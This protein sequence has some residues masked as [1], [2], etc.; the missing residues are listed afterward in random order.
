MAFYQFYT[1][2]TNGDHVGKEG[3]R[4][5]NAHAAN[6][7]AA[8]EIPAVLDTFTNQSG[9]R[10]PATDTTNLAQF[11]GTVNAIRF[12]I[13]EDN[14]NL[15]IG[16]V[17][18]AK[19]DYARVAL[20]FYRLRESQ[21]GANGQ[22]PSQRYPFSQFCISGGTNATIGNFDTA[23]NANLYG[24]MYFYGWSGS[25]FVRSWNNGVN[26]NGTTCFF[27]KQVVDNVTPTWNAVANASDIVNGGVYSLDA[28]GSTQYI[29]HKTGDYFFLQ[30]AS[31]G[32][33]LV[34]AADGTQARGEFP[35]A[36]EGSKVD[37]A[38]YGTRFIWKY[39]TSGVLTAYTYAQNEGEQQASTSYN[40]T[41]YKQTYHVHSGT[42]QDT[43]EPTCTQ[44][45]YDIYRCSE[46]GEPYYDNYVDATGHTFGSWT[47]ISDTQHQRVCT[48][49]NGAEEGGIEVA[50]HGITYTHNDTTHTAT[51]SV[52]GWTKTEAHSDSEI[53]SR[54][55]PQCGN[56]GAYTYACGYVKVIPGDGS[57]TPDG[58]IAVTKPT[59]TTAGSLTYMCNNCGETVETREIPAT[60]H[61]YNAD[62]KCAI[63]GEMKKVTDPETG[64]LVNYKPDGDYIYQY[65][66]VPEEGHEYVIANTN[67]QGNAYVAA[68]MEGNLGTAY[69]NVENQWLYSVPASVA[70]TG[71]NALISN[72]GESTRW[73]YDGNTFKNVATGEY[74]WGYH[75][76]AGNDIY[77]GTALDDEEWI[78]K[79]IGSSASIGTY[80]TFANIK[81]AIGTSGDI[82]TNKGVGTQVTTQDGYYLGFKDI[83]STKGFT[84]PG[85]GVLWLRN[86]DDDEA[87]SGSYMPFAGYTTDDGTK[88]FANGDNNFNAIEE[89]LSGNCTI[90]FDYMFTGNKSVLMVAR[91]GP[92]RGVQVTSVRLYLMGDCIF[93]V[94]PVYSDGNWSQVSYGHAKIPGFTLNEW[95]HFRLVST[96]TATGESNVGDGNSAIVYIDGEEVLKAENWS[97]YQPHESPYRAADNY[98]TLKMFYFQGWAYFNNG[99]LGT[100]VT[101]A[102]LTD[103]FGFTCTPN[104]HGPDH[105]SDGMTYV[106]NVYATSPASSIV[107]YDT[108]D[109][110]YDADN[111][112]KNNGNLFYNEQTAKVINLDGATEVNVNADIAENV[113][114]ADANNTNRV[115]FYEKVE[116][117]KDVTYAVDYAD[118]VINND[119]FPGA[120]NT[121]DGLEFAGIVETLPADVKS[122]WVVNDNLTTVGS[123]SKANYS[124][125]ATLATKTGTETKPEFITFTSKPTDYTAEFYAK[126][127]AGNKFLYQKIELVPATTFYFEDASN[128]ITYT[129]TWTTDGST[130]GIAKAILDDVYGASSTLNAAGTKLYSGGAAHKLALDSASAAG[131][132]ASF[133]FKGTGVDI[134]SHV[135]GQT[136]IVFVDIIGESA[137]KKL[138]VNTY[139]GYAYYTDAAH[140]DAG[141]P[142][143][144]AGEGPDMY[145]IPIIHVTDLPYGEYTVTI[146]PAYQ[147]DF[148]G[149]TEGTTYFWL[150]AV[151]VYEPAAPANEVAQAVYV[152][153][154][155]ANVDV[156]RIGEHLVSDDELAYNGSASGAMY[157]IGGNDGTFG[158]A[159]YAKIGPNNEVYL[160]R[161]QYVS[162]KIS[163]ADTVVI[164]EVATKVKPAKILVS[165]S[166]VGASGNAN[167]IVNGQQIAAIATGTDMYYDI[168]NAV[169]WENGSDVSGVITISN[170][171]ANILSLMNLKVAYRGAASL[172]SEFTYAATLV[173]LPAAEMTAA[174]L[175]SIRSGILLG[176]VDGDGKMNTKDLALLKKY[177]SGI[178]S[179]EFISAQAADIN[180]D[181]KINSADITALKKLI[182][183]A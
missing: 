180:G 43:V 40:L 55:E 170:N 31:T 83:V 169:A 163:G 89:E 24:Q 182:A 28:S 14:K 166:S 149:K 100:N 60:G 177:I 58:G 66:D 122:S 159:D 98:H 165:A 99:T 41:L 62:G 157:F 79:N 4:Y 176:D 49:C 76:T 68:A 35:V 152:A 7:W 119:K 45:G 91:V 107:F 109:E 161:N 80:N 36:V 144:D 32:D 77:T 25:N 145:Q 125:G 19:N 82:S 93:F 105:F 173:S 137:T 57:H 50:S 131:A 5:T 87:N 63:C 85:K 146:E 178:A 37:Y 21:Y 56:P 147:R 155:E 67:I 27:E 136:G 103:L 113:F 162:F 126:Y 48:V 64:E 96:R 65:V 154:N 160:A 30:N 128:F 104:T 158:P 26:V 174:T 168:T 44:Q 140:V 94:Q 132:T 10:T 88:Y 42:Y 183:G 92:W 175:A 115:Y 70:G 18:L 29:L 123:I 164:D 129:G 181:G 84:L 108:Y 121:I 46:C 72:Q 124:I 71:E 142:W 20:H 6:Q 11:T 156:I 33:L 148:R 141:L 75:E 17:F 47:S 3:I 120:D 73:Y 143:D 78:H 81:A 138:F 69:N 135:S 13:D 16:S 97:F 110:Y 1:G 39:N 130:S 12:D 22:Y 54:V 172:G 23:L 179:L 53:V 167:L 153:D 9:K 15:F 61:F 117:P 38:A 151:R 74:L 118:I 90:D 2:T 86:D 133:T 51:C 111:N 106:D 101:N 134:I 95:H 52:C 114:I 150:D 139:T 112:K 102:E 8:M 34:S 127:K 116:A 171:S 59:C